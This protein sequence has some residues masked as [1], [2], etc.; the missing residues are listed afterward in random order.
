MFGSYSSNHITQVNQG[1]ITTYPYDI[2]LDDG[3]SDR[4]SSGGYQVISRDK[5]SVAATHTQYY[6]LDMN[7]DKDSDDKADM[8]VWYCLGDNGNDAFP[9]DVRNNYYIYSY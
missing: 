9:N 4:T 6:Q 3:K 5:T 2:N 8:V 7:L 1:Q